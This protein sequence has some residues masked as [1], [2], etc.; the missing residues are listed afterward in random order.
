MLSDLT[1][2]SEGLLERVNVAVE[3]QRKANRVL[4]HILGAQYTLGNDVHLIFL[5][6]RM[7]T[8]FSTIHEVDNT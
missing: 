8:E 5:H 3:L 2:K 4:V 7:I 6:R 1:A